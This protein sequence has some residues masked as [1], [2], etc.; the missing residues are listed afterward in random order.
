MRPRPGRPLIL[1][2][3][4]EGRDKLTASFHG[5]L[6]NSIEVP[7]GSGIV[8]CTTRI[9]ALLNIRES[10]DDR[11]F[12]KNWDL[13]SG[14]RTISVLCVHISDKKGDIRGVTGMI[15]GLDGVF[16]EDDEKMIRVFNI[17][18]GISLENARPSRA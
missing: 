10:Y 13:E 16:T 12:D 5:G 1:S 18:T 14:Y 3:V 9:T 2:L 15:N 4:N 17:F 11:H 6:A 8:G 7:I